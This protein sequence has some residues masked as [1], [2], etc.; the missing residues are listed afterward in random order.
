[1]PEKSICELKLN[2]NF[3]AAVVKKHAVEPNSRK[4]TDL[5]LSDGD[6]CQVGAHHAE[7]RVNQ[8]A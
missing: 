7:L 1:M 2:F 8:D 4:L 3:K 6:N 5:L